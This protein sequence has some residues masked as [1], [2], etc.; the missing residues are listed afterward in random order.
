MADVV[1]LNYFPTIMGISDRSAINNSTES[2][3]APLL[4]QWLKK[5]VLLLI[6][7]PV[8]AASILSLSG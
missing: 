1:P 6:F 8:V 5:R 4:W 7:L 3:L 2:Q